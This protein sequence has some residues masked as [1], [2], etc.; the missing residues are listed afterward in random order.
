MLGSMG[1]L[2]AVPL[3]LLIISTLDSFESTR[4]MVT[5][6]RVAPHRQDEVEQQKARKQIS[7][8]WERAKGFVRPE[9][10]VKKV[11]GSVQPPLPLEATGGKEKVVKT[12]EV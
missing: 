3:T 4:W 12:P 6:I 5:L 11:D 10:T 1:A 7:G 2:L 8:L 9:G